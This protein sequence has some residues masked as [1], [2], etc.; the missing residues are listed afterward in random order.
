M[1]EFNLLEYLQVSIQ[2]PPSSPS[3]TSK[4]TKILHISFYTSFKNYF[5]L[6]LSYSTKPTTL[7]EKRKEGR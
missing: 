7:S 2:D 3:T 6:T 4:E 5:S 1:S